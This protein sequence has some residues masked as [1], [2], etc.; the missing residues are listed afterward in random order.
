MYLCRHAQVSD[1]MAYNSDSFP[2]VSILKRKAAVS[3]LWAAE[4]T[5]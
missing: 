5:K 3:N 4:Q 2:F 1:F